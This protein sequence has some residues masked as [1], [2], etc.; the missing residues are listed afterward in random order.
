MRNIFVYIAIGAPYI[1]LFNGLSYI[2][3]GITEMFID[4]PKTTKEESKVTFKDDFKI[5]IKFIINF[6]V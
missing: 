6:K 3:S 4:I 1:F 2:L 5:K